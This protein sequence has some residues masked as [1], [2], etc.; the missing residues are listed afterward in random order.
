LRRAW[1]VVEWDAMGLTGQLRRAAPVVLLLGFVV[2]WR[3]WPRA[4]DEELIA[5]VVR[6]AKHGVET[7]D[8][9]EVMSCVSPEY[10]DTQGLT[11]GQV[12]RLAMVWAR[13]PQ[14][15]SVSVED[16]RLTLAPPEASATLTVVMAV[17]GQ[18]ALDSRRLPVTVRFRKERRGLGSV[19]LV[20]AVEGYELGGLVEG[21]G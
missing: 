2:A 14:T 4:S 3:V 12:L 21:T 8:V 5:A 9:K 6:R 18:G 13:E 1:G 17:T 7:K 20:H 10:R 16:Y 11:R 15:A 19:W